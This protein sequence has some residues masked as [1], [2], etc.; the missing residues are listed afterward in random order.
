MVRLLRRAG[1]VGLLA[2][3]SS[4]C[5]AVQRGE[6]VARLGEVR[7][8]QEGTLQLTARA[9][10]AVPSDEQPRQRVAVLGRVGLEHDRLPVL[11]RGRAHPARARE[12][13]CELDVYLRELRTELR[14]AAVE[15]D[16]LAQPA[17]AL[18]D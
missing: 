1:A 2:R 14:G 15:H 5:R 3:T 16:R 4:R 18:V 7:A 13:T 10:E 9:R 8:E 12:E 17:L 11:R 6:G